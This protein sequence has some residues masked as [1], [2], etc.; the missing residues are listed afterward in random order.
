MRR[1]GGIGAVAPGQLAMHFLRIARQQRFEVAAAR[2]QLAKAQLGHAD[3]AMRQHAQARQPR[4]LRE[5]G[6]PRGD[7]EGGPVL[8]AR[9]VIEP[10]AIEGGEN[11]RGVVE[12]LAQLAQ[13]AIDLHR[14]LGGEAGQCYQRRAERRQQIELEPLPRR[15]VSHGAQELQAFLQMIA[16]LDIGG[17][18]RG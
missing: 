13:A 2:V 7:A 6:E 12:R 18:R 14:L 8:G 9:G 5:I 10:F 15:S 16:R 3:D 4:A 1:D 17:A 11:H